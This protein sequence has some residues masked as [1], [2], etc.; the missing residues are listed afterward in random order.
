[1]VIVPENLGSGDF[2]PTKSS[3]NYQV[4]QNFQE[5]IAVSGTAPRHTLR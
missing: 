2:S 4:I 1:M 5:V 3:S